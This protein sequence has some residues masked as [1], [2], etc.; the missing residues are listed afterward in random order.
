MQREIKNSTKQ[1]RGQG[2]EAQGYIWAAKKKSFGRREGSLHTTDL[3]HWPY[4]LHREYKGR[5]GLSPPVG[6]ERT[7]SNPRDTAGLLE[8]LRWGE[9]NENASIKP[10][11]AETTEWRWDICPAVSRE[12]PKMKLIRKEV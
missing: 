5:C 8:G 10:R 7:Q 6:R 1:N 2:T 9:S 11:V 12:L 4:K 3:P